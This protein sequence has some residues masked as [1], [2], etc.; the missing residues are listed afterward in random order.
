MWEIGSALSLRQVIED[1]I[2]ICGIRL[3]CKQSIGL[4]IPTPSE[5]LENLRTRGRYNS[6]LGR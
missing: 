1:V 2:V 5:R 6:S 3:G 4:W